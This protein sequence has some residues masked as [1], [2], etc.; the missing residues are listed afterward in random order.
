MRLYFINRFYWPAELATA[1]LLVDLAESLAAQNCSVSVVVC[2]SAAGLPAR[3]RRNGVEIIRVGSPPT[4]HHLAR[5]TMNAAW[6]HLAALA[7]LWRTVRPGDVIV[8]LTDPPLIG[9]TAALIARVR[10]AR[11]VHWIQDIYPEVLPAVTKS[12]IARITSGAFRP[13]R[14][15]AWRNAAACV[16][17][18]EDMAATVR[19]NLSRKNRL[20]IVPNWAPQGLHAGAAEE[21]AALRTHWGLGD[22]FIVGYSGN[23]GRVHDLSGLIQ[24]AENFR[25]DPAIVFLLVGH[26]ANYN[27]LRT[28]VDRKQLT[29]VRFLPPR[30]RGELSVSLSVPDV[31]LIS[32]RPGCEKFVFPSKLYGVAAVARPVLLLGT[33]NSELAETIARQA[34]GTVFD[35]HD[36]AGISA[37]LRRLAT[38]PAWRRSLE[39]AAGRFGLQNGGITRARDQWQNILRPLFAPP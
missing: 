27:A 34:M 28:E 10:G 20:H 25:T 35:P 3:E 23:L 37:C 7:L 31:H 8:A 5:R 29:N 13:V 12:W 11:L 1:Q 17:L 19:P 9:V 21:V 33:R 16:T 18:G 36:T 38:E 6:F 39:A 24:V 22:R 4:D 2:H 30:P 26:G 14:D 15:V 32:L